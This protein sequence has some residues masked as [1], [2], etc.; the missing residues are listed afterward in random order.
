MIYI[1]VGSQ[2]FQFDR[3]FKEIDKI[4]TSLQHEIFAQIGYSNYIPKNF[5]YSRF[6]DYEDHISTLK[7][8]DIL[9]CH[10]GTSSII[11]GLKYQKQ[12][13]VV[14][15]LAEFGEHVDDHQLE[16][17][18]VFEHKNLVKQVLNEKDLLSIILNINKNNFNKY[19]F[20]NSSL[21]KSIKESTY[22][23]L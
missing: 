9:I 6:I 5:G 21:L 4:Q 13:I 1:T 20:D 22:N 18:S 15:R 10:G 16:I 11:E 17:S 3:L 2:K 8:C 19:S 7:K 23:F 12:V 14:P